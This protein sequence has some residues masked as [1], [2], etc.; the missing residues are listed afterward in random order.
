MVAIP[1]H[2]FRLSLVASLGVALLGQSP[3]IEPRPPKP[4]QVV[5]EADGGDAAGESEKEKAMMVE[6]KVDGGAMVNPTALANYAFAQVT[7]R[8]RRLAAGESGVL[9][10]VLVLHNPAVVTAD[11][12]VL[13]EYDPKQNG[14]ELGSFSV[15]PAKPGTLPTKFKGMPVWDNTVTLEVPITVGSETPSGDKILNLRLKTPLTHGS[16][17]QL[18]GDL[19]LPI[20]GHV[21]VGSPLPRPVPIERAGGEAGAAAA[22]A[23]DGKPEAAPNKPTA[24]VATKPTNDGMKLEAAPLTG[25]SHP[26]TGADGVTLDVRMPEPNVLPLG[27]EYVAKVTLRVPEGMWLSRATPEA[28]ALEVLGVE[29][30]VDAEVGAWPAAGTTKVGD[31]EE[32]ASNGSLTVPVTFRASRDAPAG[33]CDLQF[34]LSYRKLGS[35]GGSQ[36]LDV[37][38]V[39]AVGIEPTRANPWIFYAVGAALAV[40]I[41]ALLF[42]A[43]RR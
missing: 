22:S 10:V 3:R 23:A 42:R 2:V 8:P 41:A 32:S 14:L 16:V 11:S 36:T 19:L 1:A 27:G 9:S 43:I 21:K 37:P 26:A 25:V 18:L 7:T 39:L 33:L 6:G 13:L 12:A 35:A 34:R 28:L 5:S 30:G 15:L 40:V 17:G 20:T 31:A 4:V 24:A 38:A 29:P